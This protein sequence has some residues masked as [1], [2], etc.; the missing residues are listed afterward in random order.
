[1]YKKFV[2]FLFFVLYN[3]VYMCVY[4]MIVVDIV[5]VGLYV[6]REDIVLYRMDNFNRCFF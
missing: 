5:F 4:I 6:L 3:I 2:G 1:M